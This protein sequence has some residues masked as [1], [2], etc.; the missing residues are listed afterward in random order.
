MQASDTIEL[1]QQG[2]NR[3]TPVYAS[4]LADLGHSPS[5]YLNSPQ[6]PYVSV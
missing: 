3:I 5:A 4:V 1:A 6:A 2:Y